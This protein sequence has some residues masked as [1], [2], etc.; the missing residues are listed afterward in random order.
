MHG[1]FET[2]AERM[3][4]LGLQGQALQVNYGEAPGG[5]LSVNKKKEVMF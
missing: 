1:L 4:H 5:F 2:S 3:A